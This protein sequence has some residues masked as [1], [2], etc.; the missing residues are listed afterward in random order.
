MRILSIERT[1]PYAKLKLLS[2][3]G[4]KL[5]PLDLPLKEKKFG[6]L[7]GGT[8]SFGVSGLR[9]S[10]KEDAQAEPGATPGV[11]TVQEQHGST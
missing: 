4:V 7:R 9:I 5:N 2:K 11:R 1:V 10:S 3:L 8:C 6:G